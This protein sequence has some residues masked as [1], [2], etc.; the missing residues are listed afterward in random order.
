[1]YNHILLFIGLISTIT[2]FE[3][4]SLTAIE[5]KVRKIFARTSQ[6][7]QSIYCCHPALPENHCGAGGDR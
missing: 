4:V 7:L 3:E 6:S 2:C 5:A 1:M